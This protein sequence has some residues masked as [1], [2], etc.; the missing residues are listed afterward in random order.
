MKSKMI[1]AVTAF[2]LFLFCMLTVT[3]YAKRKINEPVDNYNFDYSTCLNYKVKD[4]YGQPGH[5][6]FRTIL[7]RENTFAQY[8]KLLEEFNSADNFRY[9]EAHDVLLQYVGLYPNGDSFIPGYGSLSEEELESF[10]NQRAKAEDG[11]IIHITNIK[12]ALISEKAFTEDLSLQAHVVRGNAFSASDFLY[13][14][15]RIPVLLGYD[16]LELYQIGDVITVLYAGYPLELKVIGFL[17]NTSSVHIGSTDISLDT[18][19]LLP[20]FDIEA[21]Y[22]KNNQIFSNLHYSHKTR[23]FFTV[24]KNVEEAINEFEEIVEKSGLDYVYFPL[25]E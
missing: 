18:Y 25:P 12:G 7:H 9:I 5:E 10:I 21:E 1:I 22:A 17:D 16:Y 3:Y 2:L 13:N 8:V 6:R 11:S 15:N 20:S 19:I 14:G 23:G 4:N 24:T